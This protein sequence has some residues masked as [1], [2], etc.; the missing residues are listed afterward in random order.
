MLTPEQF[1][2]KH[3][4]RRTEDT[5]EKCW[6]CARAKARC[7]Q[8][9]DL[10]SLDEAL[11][12][13]KDKNESDGYAKPVTH[14]YCRWCGLRHM[15]TPTRGIARKRVRRSMRKWMHEQELKRRQERD[16]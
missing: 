16:Q 3:H 15:F 5:I 1:H 7:L 11:E 4:R 2:D 13:V 8:K 12:W 14:Y 9:I 10:L 6:S